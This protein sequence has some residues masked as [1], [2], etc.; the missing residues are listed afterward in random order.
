MRGLA[1]VASGECLF[2]DPILETLISNPCPIELFVYARHPMR[3]VSPEK[4]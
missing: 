2:Q 4:R 3:A 1:F